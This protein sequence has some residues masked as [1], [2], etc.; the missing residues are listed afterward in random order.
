[1]ESLLSWAALLQPFKYQPAGKPP[2]AVIGLAR[3]ARPLLQS[4]LAAASY[5]AGLAA[6]AIRVG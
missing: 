3:L 4:A 2:P 1:M 6:R 5:P